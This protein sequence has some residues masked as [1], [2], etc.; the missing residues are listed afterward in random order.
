MMNTLICFLLQIAFTIGMIFLFGFLIALCNKIFYSNFGNLSKAVCYITGAIGTPIHE[1]AHALFCLIFGHKIIEIKLFQINSEDGTL[2]YVCHSYN[3]KNLY[4]KIGNFF[5]GIAP[6]TV[7][8]ALLYLFSWLLLPNFVTEISNNFKINDFLDNIGNVFINLFGALQSFFSC[9]NLWQW[10]VFLIIGIFL[11][12]HMTL[13]K[14]DI[15][16]ALSGLVLLLIVVLIVDIILALIGGDYLIS[17]TQ[18]I[19]YVASYLICFLSLS[20]IVS[21]I[22]VIVS[23]AFKAYKK[24]HKPI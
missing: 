18:K 24:G 10:W 4:H 20:L 17:F 6:I 8:S 11:S 22:A 7:I 3:P 14:E 16:G 2:G 1:C 23:F 12:L 13:S 9:A 19:L 5:I 21:I 15:K